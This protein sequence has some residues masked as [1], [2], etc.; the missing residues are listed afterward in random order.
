MDGP[1]RRAAC[2]LA[3]HPDLLQHHDHSLPYRLDGY[4][5]RGPRPLLVP[6]GRGNAFYYRD[7]AASLDEDQPF[8]SFSWLPPDSV[9]SI[10]EMAEKYVLEIMSAYPAGSLLLGGYCFGAV[11]A[12]EMAH[13]LRNKGRDIT[14][15]YQSDNR[16]K[17]VPTKKE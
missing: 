17:T 4:G 11:V 2:R 16:S 12:L 5:S 13:L 3:G 1:L 10:E 15:L 6:P 9:F 14:C 7:L 8:Y